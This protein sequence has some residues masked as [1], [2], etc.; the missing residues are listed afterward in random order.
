V[1]GGGVEAYPVEKRRKSID[2]RWK[3]QEEAYC[4]KCDK[5]IPFT[6]E[7]KRSVGE[8]GWDGEL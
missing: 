3:G 8:D 2:P 4:P 1:C 6:V 5:W 7:A